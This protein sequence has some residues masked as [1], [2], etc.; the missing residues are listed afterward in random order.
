MSRLAIVLL[1]LLIAH[2]AVAQ[3]GDIMKYKDKLKKGAKVATAVAHET[4][5]EEEKEIGRVVAARVLATYPLS[6]KDRLQKYVTLVG[7][8]VAAY[9]SR[10]TLEWHFAVL[11]TPLVNAFSAPGGYLFV[12]TGALAQMHSEAELAAVLGHEIA[13]A[14]EKHILREIRRANVYAA[15]MDIV[16][17]RVSALNDDIAAKIGNMAHEKLFKTGIGRKE[18]IDADR[19]GSELASKA[20]YRADA[21]VSFLTSLQALAAHDGSALSQL[22]ATHPSS[23][24]R[25]KALGALG[26]SGESLGERFVA[27][28]E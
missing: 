8:T 27:W 28:T 4:T 25:V 11:E 1:S 22:T 7:R 13:H 9:S 19:I 23:D 6:A 20:G 16:D 5:E 2:P 10:P 3:F 17:D 21:L 12:T 14:T 18:E 24:A 26:T 15:G